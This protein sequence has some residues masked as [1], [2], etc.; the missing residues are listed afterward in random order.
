M[1]KYPSTGWLMRAEILNI[2][3][4]NFKYPAEKQGKGWNF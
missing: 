2:G 1:Y 3:G 4:V